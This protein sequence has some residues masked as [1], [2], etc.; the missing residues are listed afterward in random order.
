[1]ASARNEAPRGWSVRK[2]CLPSLRTRGGVWGCGY[3]PSPELF[4]DFWVQNG[5]LWCILEANFIALELSVLYAHKAGKPRLWLVKPAIALLCVKKVGGGFLHDCP[6]RPAGDTSSLPPWWI[7]HWS[8]LFLCIRSCLWPSAD[9]SGL[10]RAI[11][12]WWT[13]TKHADA[14]VGESHTSI[15]SR[16]IIGFS[17]SWLAD[18]CFVLTAAMRSSPPSD[19]CCS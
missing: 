7:R 1:M 19:C 4:F 2:G 9:S 13:S 5:E 11:R 12:F 15:Y 17:A 18:H 16:P 10:I 8:S 3:A 6:P 14:C